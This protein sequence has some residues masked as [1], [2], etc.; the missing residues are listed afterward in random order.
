MIPETAIGEFAYVAL[1][2]R[3]EPRDPNPEVM[4]LMREID[5]SSY[6]RAASMDS[7]A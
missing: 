3:L 4:E 6:L 5:A 2:G 1:K 7:A